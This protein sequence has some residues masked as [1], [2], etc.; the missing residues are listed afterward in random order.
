M[1]L[2]AALCVDDGATGVVTP[3]GTITTGFAANVPSA[4]PRG[5]VASVLVNP[6]WYNQAGGDAIHD[7]ALFTLTTPVTGVLPADIWLGN[8]VGMVGA[9]LGFGYQD[10]GLG[11]ANTA[12]GYGYYL[13]GGEDL[14]SAQ[15]RID[16]FD[17]NVGFESDFDNSAGT[18][19]SLGSRSKEPLVSATA[20]A[21]CSSR[22]RAGDAGGRF[23]WRRVESVWPLLLLRRCLELVALGERREHRVPSKQPSRRGFRGH[24]RTRQCA[25]DGRRMPGRTSRTP[26]FAPFL[27]GGCCTTT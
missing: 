19:S 21:L 22:Q 18:T 1:V 25:L 27:T 15:N 7:Q 6:G 5:N 14:L 20:P 3:A 16:A 23:E 11:V 9:L 12:A 26:P 4:I 13:P 2:T 10:T 17:P 8:P 24:P